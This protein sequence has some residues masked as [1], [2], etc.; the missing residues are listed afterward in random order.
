MT[1]WENKPTDRAYATYLLKPG[2]IDYK[3]DDPTKNTVR[4]YA[5]IPGMDAF[6]MGVELDFVYKILSNL[7]FQG[8]VSVGDWKWDKQIKGLQYYNDDTDNP[9]NYVLDFNAKGIHVGDAAQTQ[10]AA[11]IRYEPVKNIYISGRVTYFDRYYA[12]FSPEATTDDEGNPVDS[13]KLPSYTLVDTHIGYNFR[14][15]AIDKLR[16]SW[17]LSILNALN[18]KYISDATNNDSY[19]ELPFSDFDAKSATVFFGAPR[20]V[21][22]TLQISF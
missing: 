1:R 7:E 21:S 20:S 13:W 3:I 16:F 12:E 22:T 2:D 9:V 17:K 19:S 15:K 6:H 14:I 4:V 10:L 11:T 18:T 8:L 5:D